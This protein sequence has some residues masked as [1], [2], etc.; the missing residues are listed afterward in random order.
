MAEDRDIDPCRVQRCDECGSDY[1][2]TASQMSHLCVECS[3]W[4]YGYPPCEHVFVQ[5]RCS[6]CGWDGSI[7]QYIR[8]LR[9]QS[10]EPGA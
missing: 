4:L 6:R 7:S 2:V 1:L 10:S 9:S 3:H 5:G 8:N